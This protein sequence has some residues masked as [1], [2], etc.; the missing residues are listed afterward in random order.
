MNR[1]RFHREYTLR[2]TNNYSDFVSLMINF[3]TKLQTLCM[4]A[5]AIH[6]NVQFLQTSYLIRKIHVW[7]HNII[8]KSAS[9]WQSSLESNIWIHAAKKLSQMFIVLTCSAEVLI[10]AQSNGIAKC[11][12]TAGLVIMIIMVSLVYLELDECCYSYASVPCNDTFRVPEG[13][14]VI[15]SCAIINPHSMTISQ[16]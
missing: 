2:V 9:I 4:M 10:R 6:S 15:L 3:A 12:S 1:F 13:E 11:Y 5:H 7:R 8:D 14:L 16:I